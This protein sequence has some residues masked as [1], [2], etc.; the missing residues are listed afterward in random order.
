MGTTLFGCVAFGTDGDDFVIT[1]FQPPAPFITG[2][3]IHFEIHKGTP[4]GLC[5]K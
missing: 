4:Y 3:S 1:G 5:K 2:I